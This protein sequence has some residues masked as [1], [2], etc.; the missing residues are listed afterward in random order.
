MLAPQQ[1]DAAKKDS[2]YFMVLLALAEAHLTTSYEDEDPD[3][4]EINCHGRIRNTP[5]NSS[6]LYLLSYQ[7][8]KEYRTTNTKSDHLASIE[9][10]EC[11]MKGT[12]T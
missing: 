9:I 2:E 1:C 4:H 10:N 3:A 6:L 5:E 11:G 8:D 7:K 12:N